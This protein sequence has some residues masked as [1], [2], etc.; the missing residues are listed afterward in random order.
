[1]LALQS[2]IATSVAKALKVTLLEDAGKKIELGGT[3]VPAAFDAYLRGVKKAR[4]ALSDE[5]V[6]AVIAAY[7]EAIHLDPRFALAFAVRSL[8]LTDYARFNAR[9]TEVR[10]SFDKALADARTAVRLAPEL[11]E[12]HVALAF[13]LN[14]GFF[15]FAQADQEY[16]RALAL[17]PGDARILVSYSRN[18]AELGRTTA[19]ISAARRAVILDPL[20]FHV[21]RMVGIVFL[22]ARQYADA[23]NAFRKAIA[24]QPDYLPNY[25]LLGAAQYEQGDFEAA[26]SSCEV[27]LNDEMGQGCLAMVYRKLGRD[28]DAE[29]MLKKVSSSIGENTA[30][31]V[32]TIYAQWGDIPQA[33]HWLEIAVRRRYSE[34]SALRTEPDLDP[35]RKEPRFQ[36]LE[37]E[38]KF[39]N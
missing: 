38:L 23:V 11:A 10:A 33:L 34:L 3:Q 6:Q 2:E 31:D 4:T 29:A 12:A 22:L 39:P 21:H 28:V 26:R 35:L 24:L 14:R 36:A 9:G 1:V 20:N 18:A 8:D 7:T 19:A 30:Y 32:A 25:A 17:A 16:E 5:A 13:V 15:E 27:A 37:R